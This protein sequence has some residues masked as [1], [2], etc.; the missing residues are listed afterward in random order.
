MIAFQ[1]T[2]HAKAIIQIIEVAEK[3]S[4][5]NKYSI[6]NQGNTQKNH[7]K[8]VIIITPAIQ[9]LLNCHTNIK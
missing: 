2:I 8:N 5:F 1:T 3:Y 6:V 9:K 4:Q 7:S